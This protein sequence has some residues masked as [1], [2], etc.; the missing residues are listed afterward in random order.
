MNALR[1]NSGTKIDLIDDPETIRSLQAERRSPITRSQGQKMAS[2]IK[3]YKYGFTKSSH[4]HPHMHIVNFRY[5][6]CSALTQNG[7]G[8]VG[9]Y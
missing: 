4:K 8:T 6:E 5:L 7:L 2:K 3:A 1:Q 9:E